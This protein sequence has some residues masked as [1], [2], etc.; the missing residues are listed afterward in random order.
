[1]DVVLRSAEGCGDDPF[2]L[3][4]TI[5]NTQNGV[6]GWALAGADEAL[7]RGGLSAKAGLFTAV[8]LA[9]F[10]D[11]R[12]PKDHPLAYLADGDPRGWWGDGVDVRDDLGE[13]ELGSLLWSLERAPLTDDIVVRWAPQF[14][15]DAL[16]PLQKQQAVTRID[17]QTLAN[18]AQSRLELTVQLYGKDGA[19][20]F[21]AKFDLL[22]KQVQG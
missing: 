17:A 1:M 12:M 18:P 19:R 5:W 6:G 16:M 4:D 7:N 8:A 2:L 13:E 10:S 22:W 15:I 11:K 9:L 3:W 21:D 20:V 14:A